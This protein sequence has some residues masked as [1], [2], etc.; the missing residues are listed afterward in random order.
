MNKPVT[1]Y[2]HK[3]EQNAVTPQVAYNNTSAAFDI[4]CIKTTTIPAR[5]S[6]VVPN[7]LNLTIDQE[8]KYYMYLQLRSSI[9]FKREMVLHSGVVDSGY[10]GDLGIKLYNLG[11]E[12]VIINE[13]ERYAQVL[14]IPRPE[15]KIQ[16]LNDEEFEDLKARQ[17]RGS[18]GFGSS[19]RF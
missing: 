16:V 2:A 4:T 9:G 15:Y 7:G 14:V 12:D 5:G 18:S 10:T 6:A 13:G 3:T 8:D 1:I 17:L 11:D 19:G